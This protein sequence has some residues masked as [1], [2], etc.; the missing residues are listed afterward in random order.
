MELNHQGYLIHYLPDQPGA[1]GESQLSDLHI[2]VLGDIDDPAGIGLAA[3]KPLVL[4]APRGAIDLIPQSVEAFGAD[5]QHLA[6]TF[7]DPLGRLR[8]LHGYFLTGIQDRGFRSS[9]PQWTGPN[10][11]PH[12]TLVDGE[13]SSPEGFLQSMGGG[14]E[15]NSVTLV[16]SIFDGEWNFLRGEPLVT[17][18]LD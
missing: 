6:M 12:M 3:L 4:N 16:D 7:G 15:L 8:E 14:F 17:V 9:R 11:R 2:T 10:F 5:G 13:P 18:T 1:D